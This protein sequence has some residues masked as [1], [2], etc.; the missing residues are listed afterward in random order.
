M[1]AGRPKMCGSCGKLMGVVDVCPYCGA[2]N[3]RV[4]VRLKRAVSG[5][6]LEKGLGAYP[7]TTFMVGANVLLFLVTMLY[8]GAEP[9]RGLE[10]VS[11]NGEALL[12]LGAHHSLAIASGEWW[13][14]ITAVF[15][16]GG[17][18]HVFFNSFILWIAGRHLEAEFGPRLMFLI[19]MLS[20]V[21]GFVGSYFFGITFTIG[22]SGAVSGI[23]GALLVRRWLVDGNL[24]HPITT[25]VIQLIV[26]TA[27][28]GLAVN[29][30]N[31]VAHV[32]GFVTGAGLAFALTKLRLPKLVA[33]GLMLLTTALG[34][35][36]VIAFGAMALGLTKGGGED[37]RQAL[38]CTN[39]A[40][41]AVVITGEAREAEAIIPE[42]AK[43]ALTC[44]DELP[45]IDGDADDALDA[46]ESGLR[47][48][49]EAHLDGDRP[50]EQ[51]GG[52][53]ALVGQR[54]FIAWLEAN[55]ARYNLPPLRRQRR[56]TG[57]TE[58]Q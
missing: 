18:V 22:A 19:Y 29:T 53:E 23:L 35:A 45:T 50:E 20:G 56:A 10:V 49:I 48:A 33:V 55:H 32:V 5:R 2:D 4:R 1:V 28:Y 17:L 58:P 41:V 21:L 12:R 30:V 6:S 47:L 38:A 14:L 42:L 37:V 16:H 43:V 36:T 15:L 7:V 54:R 25:W 44:L 46:I 3:K 39:K 13:R 31:N 57:M 24:R 51:R 27:I 8:G 26:I 34:V 40:L 52:N 11:T 9:A